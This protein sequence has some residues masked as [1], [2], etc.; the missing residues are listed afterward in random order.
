MESRMLSH[1][2]ERINLLEKNN[3]I[4]MK[5]MTERINLLEQNN[6]LKM[7]EITKR[8]DLMEQ[9]NAVKMKDITER[10][11]LFEQN[12]TLKMQ[13]ITKRIDL[14]EQNN[15]VKMTD[16][17]ERMNLFE[18]N[19]GS[20]VKDITKQME[21][22]KTNT[23][24]IQSKLSDV[25]EVQNDLVHLSNNLLSQ[26]TEM[27]TQQRA[28]LAAHMKDFVSSSAALAGLIQR[29]IDQTTG[30]G[31]ILVK[32]NLDG[33]VWVY[34]NTSNSHEY[35][36]GWIV[37]QNR[38]EG[39][40]GFNRNW[41]EYRNGF[42]NKKGEHW[43]GLLWLKNI[44]STGGHELLIMYE[45]FYGSFTYAHYDNFMIGHESEQF[46]V[47]SLGNYTGTSL[48]AYMKLEVGLKFPQTIRLTLLR[49]LRRNIWDGG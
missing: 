8:I 1:F 36:N 31:V 4:K 9:N 33:Y 13:E 23:E 39:K 30:S 41:N 14:M 25:S 32:T 26:S 28:E 38:F 24:D 16:I 34:R 44:L 6:T 18:Q 48:D 15:V 45:T 43:L 47:K 40:V 3:A 7:Q 17:T 37:V 22:I 29:R 42:G 35:G 49:V 21:T 20:H 11:T 46:A 12:N 10:I 27:K 19:I 5:D 2:D